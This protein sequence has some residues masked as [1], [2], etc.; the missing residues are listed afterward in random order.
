MIS[1]KQIRQQ[2][3]TLR[4]SLSLSESQ[5]AAHRMAK[6]AAILDIFTHARHIAGYIAVNLEMDPAPLLTLALARGK[7]VYLPVL[8]SK[9]EPMVFAPYRPGAAVLKPN[10]FG[11]PEP[12]VPSEQML[13]PQ[14]L[15]LVL[16]PLVAFDSS[17]SRLGMGGGFYDRTFAFAHGHK[18]KKRPYL[19]GLG[20]EIQKV[21]KLISEPWDIALDGIVTEAAFYCANKDYANK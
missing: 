9:Q 8:Q 4:S 2:I 5:Q 18:S 20:Y 17:G 13:P 15:D 14:S 1:A 3:R 10:R 12:D 16:T 19:L 21:S 11:I 7:S 6:R